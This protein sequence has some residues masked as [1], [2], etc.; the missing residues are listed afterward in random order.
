MGK[1]EAIEK[2]NNYLKE[3]I[4]NIDNTSFSNIN[5]SKPV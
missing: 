1:K 2:A 4:L 5:K 3:E